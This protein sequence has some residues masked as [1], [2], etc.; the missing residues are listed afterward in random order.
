MGHQRRHRLESCVHEA[1]GIYD[2]PVIGVGGEPLQIEMFF[3]IFKSV[4]FLSA[5]I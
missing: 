3:V 4:L 2:L 5:L 1:F